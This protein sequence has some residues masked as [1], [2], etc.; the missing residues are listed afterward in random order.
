[1]LFFAPALELFFVDFFNFLVGGG[2]EIGALDLPSDFLLGRTG[3]INVDDS[4][5][6][7]MEGKTG[8]GV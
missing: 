2:D 3:V 7:G 1:M 4:G 8:I 5:D 6:I